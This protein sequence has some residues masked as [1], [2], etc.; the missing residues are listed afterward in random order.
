MRRPTSGSP[1]VN[2]PACAGKPGDCPTDQSQNGDNDIELIEDMTTGSRSART[3]ATGSTWSFATSAMLTAMSVKI[4]GEKVPI[5]L[6]STTADRLRTLGLPVAKAGATPETGSATISTIPAEDTVKKQ[7]ETAFETVTG[8]GGRKSIQQ[9]VIYDIPSSR[10][11]NNFVTE[12][13]SNFPFGND[14]TAIL[15]SRPWSLSTLSPYHNGEND[16]GSGNIG[17]ARVPLQAVTDRQTA[18]FINIVLLVGI[19]FL[20]V[21]FSVVLI[22][23]VLYR[24]RQR[25]NC[26]RGY[27]VPATCHHH[28][29]AGGLMTSFPVSGGGGVS[30]PNAAVM[31]V[32]KLI[33]ARRPPPYQ[34]Q[35]N[36][37]RAD[38]HVFDAGIAQHPHFRSV[39]SAA[40]ELPAD[41]AG[42]T[43]G[44]TKE[45]FV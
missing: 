7:S 16:G 22:C 42:K 45:W 3:T 19:A 14:V 44:P 36:E 40:E 29:G 30:T 34:P 24:R 38:D 26:D 11:I 18:L 23:L 4:T 32:H 25:S 33:D 9:S 43:G 17:A 10:D 6:T 20:V 39:R 8:N 1:A 27:V 5:Y 28:G 21:V 37:T 41:R 2:K 15:A 31:A 13:S 35:L 12:R